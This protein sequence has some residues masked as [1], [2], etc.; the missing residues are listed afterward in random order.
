M[1]AL[2]L[3]RTR[4]E[5]M[6][7]RRAGR[8]AVELWESFVAYHAAFRELDALKRDGQ[9]EGEHWCELAHR[10]E[11]A[12]DRY[13]DLHRELLAAGYDDAWIAR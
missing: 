1:I 2:G 10:L 7:R 3:Q 8:L 6:N 12:G 4:R 11:E 5:N 13:A 9:A